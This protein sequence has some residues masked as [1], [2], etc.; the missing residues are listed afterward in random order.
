MPVANMPID[1]FW[2]YVPAGG[3]ETSLQSQHWNIATWGASR[4]SLPTLRGQDY[5]QPYRAGLQ[6]RAK[7]PNS[8]T[9]TLSM[10][11]AGISQTTGLPDATD[12]RLAFNNNLQQ[13]RQLFWNRNAQGSEQG[14]LIRR[15]WLT[16]G[17]TNKIVKATS[18][19]EIAGTMEPTMNGRLGASFAVDLLLSDPY[20][21]GVAQ[22]QAVT[23]SGATITNLGEGV[24]GEGYPSAVNAFTITLTGG[25]CTITNVTAGV[26]VTYNTTVVSSPVTLDILNYTATDNSGANVIANVKHSGSRMWMALVP[27]AN[28]ITVTAGTATFNWNPPYV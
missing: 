27:G 10:W 24:V 3:A 11:T 5:E 9:V 16:Q 26:S 13:I 20:F 14:Q 2:S 4:F 17:G 8:K 28:V 22:T 25:P 6:W 15:W 18:M 19:A 21:Y 23:T 12:K 7:Y 1:E